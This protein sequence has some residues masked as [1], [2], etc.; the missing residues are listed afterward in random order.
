MK[1]LSEKKNATVKSSDYIG[2]QLAYNVEMAVSRSL[3][4]KAT[5]RTVSSECT[6][7]FFTL[8]HVASADRENSLAQQ[9]ADG[10]GYS[11]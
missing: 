9:F 6:A 5:S 8:G 11:Y 1:P 10:K 2:K 7:G 3:P 4:K